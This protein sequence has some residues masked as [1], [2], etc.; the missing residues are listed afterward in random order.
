MKRPD[1]WLPPMEKKYQTLLAKQCWELVPLPP[2]TNLTRGRWTYAIKFDAEGN[3]LKCKACYVAQGYTQ[4]Q[5][6]DY[7][8]TYGG[9]ARMESV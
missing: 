6:Q 9:V 4:I 8:K 7:D 5:G 2:D 1:L 3:L